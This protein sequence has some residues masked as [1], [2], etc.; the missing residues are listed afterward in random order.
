MDIRRLMG[1]VPLM[2]LYAS[3]FAFTTRAFVLLG[4]IEYFR[5]EE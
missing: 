2:I 1:E 4:M 3:F 5:Q